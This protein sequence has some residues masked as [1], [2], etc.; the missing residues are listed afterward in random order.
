METQ[1]TTIIRM[2][3]LARKAGIVPDSLVTRPVGRH[4]LPLLEAVLGNLSDSQACV[5]DCS[6][7]QIMDA[8]FADEVFGPLTVSRSRRQSR[9]GCLILDGLE[10]SNLDN[11]DMALSSRTV[12]ESGLR[13]CVLPVR[14]VQQGTILVGKCEAHVQGTFELLTRHRQLTARELTDILELDIAAASTRLKVL[15][16][17][18]LATRIEERDGQVKQFVYTWPL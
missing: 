7:I 10:G 1:T 15:F 11:L 3:E 6:D 8:S 12:R 14:N 5:L 13:N 4:F 9:S 2:T 18:G 17:L 16:D